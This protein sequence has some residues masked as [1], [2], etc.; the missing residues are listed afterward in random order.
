MLKSDILIRG[1]MWYLLCRTGTLDQRAELIHDTASE[2]D[3]ND[4]RVTVGSKSVVM[5]K[6]RWK[7]EDET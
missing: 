6:K 5:P 1:F 3:A 2:V 4:L 7:R